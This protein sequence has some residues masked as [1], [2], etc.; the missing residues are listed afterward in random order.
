MLIGILQSKVV[1]RILAISIAAVVSLG[2]VLPAQATTS[3]GSSHSQTVMFGPLSCEDG[4]ECKTGGSHSQTVLFGPLSCEDGGECKVG[5][6]GPGGGVVFYVLDPSVKSRWHYLEASPENW[7][8]G[9][10]DPQS[11]WCQNEKVFVKSSLTGNTP[12]K[13]VTSGLIGSGAKNTQSIL[14]SCA[15]GA[16]NVSAAYRGGGYGNW[17]L[18]SKEE[19]KL[20]YKNRAA[21]GGFES[22]AYWSSTELAGSYSGAQS[23]INGT[24]FFTQKCCPRYVRP[25]RT[26]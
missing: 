13:S 22:G 11:I 2:S 9:E 1:H 18:P 25:I 4:G 26:F 23:F 8:D 19:L 15:S 7:N 14:G 5:D 12:A 17:F 16:A 24:Q 3:T 20:M 10:S 6:L 21:I